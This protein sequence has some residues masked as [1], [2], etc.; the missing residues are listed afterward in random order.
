MILDQKT[1]K[2]RNVMALDLIAV[3]FAKS[4]FDPYAAMSFFTST[5]RS[6]SNAISA[7]VVPWIP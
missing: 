4:L 6:A 1:K 2:A 3:Y 7:E 5:P